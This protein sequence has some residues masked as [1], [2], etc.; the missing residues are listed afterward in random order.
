MYT[1]H[2]LIR[3]GSGGINYEPEALMGDL[4]AFG[5]P[6]AAE[7]VPNL[8]LDQLVQ[9]KISA[10]RHLSGSGLISRA[11]CLA[12]V[13]VIE[14]KARPLRRK[15]RVYPKVVQAGRE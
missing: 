9:I 1:I 11:L 7:A 5:E 12:A 2:D 6:D 15:R 4:F 10:S 3:V 8:R 14:G 13:E